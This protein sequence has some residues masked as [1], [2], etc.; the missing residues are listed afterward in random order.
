MDGKNIVKMCIF[1]GTWVAQLVERL[2]SA[3]VCEFEPQIGLTA[4]NAEP[5]WDPLSP[6]PTDSL[7]KEINIKKK[8]NPYSPKQSATLP[9]LQWHFTGKKKKKILKFIGNPK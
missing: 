1:P 4:V 5:A 9:K 3:Q 6:S 2:T 8:K 7:S